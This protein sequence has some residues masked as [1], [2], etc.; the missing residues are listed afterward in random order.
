ME[1]NTDKDREHQAKEE[2][3]LTYVSFR[4]TA[5]DLDPEQISQQLGLIPDHAHRKGDMRK[6]NLRSTNP[7]S[8]YQTG[9]WSL[10]STLNAEETLE[11]H[12][13]SL[14]ITLISHKTTIK[15]YS[16]SMGV[17]FLCDVWESFGFDLSPNTLQDVAQL[18]A[19]LGIRINTGRTEIEYPTG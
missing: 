9:M 2:S 13:N 1:S 10:R 7:P 19:T 11:K 3:P 18:G 4:I 16:K 6:K 17:Y 12:L 15:K 5:L 14:L 8:S